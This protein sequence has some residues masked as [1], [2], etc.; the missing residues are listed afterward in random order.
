MDRKWKIVA[1]LV[2]FCVTLSSLFYLFVMGRL[3]DVVVRLIEGVGKLGGKKEN[4]R[5]RKERSGSQR[6]MSL[7]ANYADSCSPCKSPWIPSRP[8]W[9]GWVS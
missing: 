1:I 7:I 5:P 4:H 6:E 9:C 8:T 2:V 3:L